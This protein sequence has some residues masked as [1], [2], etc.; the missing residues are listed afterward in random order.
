[1]SVWFADI[2]VNGM[3]ALAVVLITY[4]GWLALKQ[5]LECRNEQSQIPPSCWRRR[6]FLSGIV[7]RAPRARSG[8]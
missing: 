3:A 6:R 8:S 1:M 4:L 2:L 7:S 5:N